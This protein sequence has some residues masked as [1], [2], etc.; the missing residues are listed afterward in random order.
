M[1]GFGFAFTENVLYVVSGVAEKGLAMGVFILLLRTVIFGLNHAFFTS[2]M[3]IGVG[4]ARLTRGAPARL[5]LTVLGWSAAVFF[6]AAHNLGTTLAEATGLLSMLLSVLA[7]WGGV[8]T[9]LLI[10]I[11]VW[12]KEQRWITE[13]LANEVQA[14]LLAGDEYAAMTSS[15]GRQRLLAKT[16][17]E[18]GWVAYRRMG[19]EHALLTELAFKKRQVRLMGDEPG[20]QAE[21]AR[22]RAAI[23]DAKG[24]LPANVVT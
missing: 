10:I 22:L 13:E 18:R 21:I 19:R 20:M 24:T 3:G 15:S 11:F 9:L 14:G 12:R 1:I 2:L 23:A 16:L 5:A 6:H 8:L 4:A 7:D 17:R